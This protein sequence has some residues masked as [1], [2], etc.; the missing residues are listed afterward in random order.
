MSLAMLGDTFNKDLALKLI[1]GYDSAA[2]ANKRQRIASGKY[3]PLKIKSESTGAK[4]AGTV[5]AAVNRVT[6]KYGKVEMNIDFDNM[7]F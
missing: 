1:A 4:N 6:A 3:N 2:A 7:E 5:A